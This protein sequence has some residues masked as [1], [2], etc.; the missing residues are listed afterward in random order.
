M[1]RKIGIR[2]VALIAITVVINLLYN[3]FLYRSDVDRFADALDSLQRNVNA[4]VLYFGE[5]SNVTCAENDTNRASIAKLIAAYF[6]GMEMN[7]ITKYASHART[8][9]SMIRSIPEGSKVKTVIVTMN[10]RSFGAG[11]INSDLENQLAMGNVFMYPIPNVFKRLLSSLKYYDHKSRTERDTLMQREWRG[12]FSLPFATNFKNTS[13]WD[14]CSFASYD[15]RGYGETPEK[16]NLRNLASHYI[17]S[18]AF[19]IDTLLNPR[20][21]DF[22]EIV[23]ECKERNIHV[24]FNILPEDLEKADSLVG[25]EL[26][27][28]MHYNTDLLVKRYSAKGA[29][30]VNNLDVLPASQF[31]DSSF[32]SEHYRALGRKIVA[33][34]VAAKL[35]QFH[36]AQFRGTRS[37][38]F[39]N[40]FETE[41]KWWSPGL[42]T[43][44]DHVSPSHAN[45]TNAERIYSSTFSDHLYDLQESGPLSLTVKL[46][47]KGPFVKQVRLCVMKGVSER[48]VYW[49]EFY[50]DEMNK[51]PL[52]NGWYSIEEKLEIPERRSGAEQLKVFITN[53]SGEKALVDDMEIMY[54]EK[55]H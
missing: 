30:M 38:R 8:Y 24:I 6:P 25:P 39:I 14:S 34:N 12:N 1:I 35:K 54:D 26:V 21:G 50:F 17:K 31:L 52:E 16:Q 40:D 13:K 42:L 20:I 47:Y 51:T 43:T 44:E 37:L 3:R 55:R 2:I 7:G 27:Q 41:S 45:E 46:R 9:L 22:D 49:K 32:T 53:L 10:L 11:W 18:Y 48:I 28:I 5:S 36:S 29:I 15:E 23:S 4:E 33:W 19:S